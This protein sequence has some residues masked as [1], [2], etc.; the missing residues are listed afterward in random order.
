MT[1]AT[2]IQIV[3]EFA[4]DLIPKVELPPFTE[5]LGVLLKTLWLHPELTET[6]SHV[7][8]SMSTHLVLRVLTGWD[9]TVL[10]L[11]ALLLTDVSTSAYRYDEGVD[12]EVSG[13]LDNVRVRIVGLIPGDSVPEGAGAHE[14][15][16]SEGTS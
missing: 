6:I 9:P 8:P 5:G 12:G 1:E 3:G 15:T 13:L 16:L 4:E 11:W 14:W 2:E 7:T 10:G